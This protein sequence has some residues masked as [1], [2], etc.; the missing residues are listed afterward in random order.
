[1]PVRRVASGGRAVAQRSNLNRGWFLGVVVI[2]LTLAGWTVVPIFIKEFT[3][4]VDAWTSNGWRYG[5]AALIWM[6]LL[7]Y[8]RRSGR[9]KPGLMRA[10]VLPGAVNACAQVMFTTSFYKIDPGL[11]TFGLRSQILA[12]TI[13]AALMYPSERA[14]IR[15]PIFLA[16]LVLLL[17]GT[18]TTVGAGDE[19]AT[20]VGA[21]GVLLALGAGVGFAG[22]TLAV[23]SCMKGYGAMES[24]AAISQYTAGA[25]IVLM[26]ILGR[27]AGVHALDM[28]PARFGLFMLSS[29]IGIAICHVLYYISIARLG[30][31][32]SSGVIQLQP[33]C[34]AT[35]SYI[36]FGEV[37]TGVQ[38]VGGAAA[39]IGAI[40]ML[41]VQHLVQSKMKP[42]AHPEAEEFAELPP[43]QIAA[44]VVAEE[45]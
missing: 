43:D 33:F 4:D 45:G 16:G 39:V 12:V 36:I 21:V 30:V 34:V 11:V 27:D 14:V 3:T 41:V 9:W 35:L 24:F 10:A 32:V 15:R 17:G 44:A 8:Q 7:V 20:R 13:G 38:W 2:L 6:P 23:R 42:A 28:P 31:T 40:T 37:L 19:F 5:L 26:L 22:Y 25:M 18:L 29:V 1:M